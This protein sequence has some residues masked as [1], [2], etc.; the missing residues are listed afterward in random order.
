M[1]NVAAVN[2]SRDD[3]EKLKMGER[4]EAPHFEVSDLARVLEDRNIWDQ[5]P[6]LNEQLE[7][8]RIDGKSL[9]IFLSAPK[10]MMGDERHNHNRFS[11]A[12]FDGMRWEDCGLLMPDG[13]S[14]G[15]REWA[16]TAHL[17]KD[18]KLSLYYTAAGFVGEQEVSFTQ[19]L[20]SASA[21]LDTSA[22][23][24]KFLN[25]K[26]H[27]ELF[28]ADGSIYDHTNSL[29]RANGA[30]KAFRDPFYFKDP[31]SGLEYILFSGTKPNSMSEFDG[32]IGI[33][34]RT[35]GETDWTLLPPIINAEGISYELE[36]AH[37]IC[38]NDKYYLFWS[39]HGWTT[40]DDVD[41]P[42]GLYGMVSDSVLG[43][44]EP[45]NGSG[46]VISNP[47]SN[48]Y[49]A[50]SWNV[51]NDLSVSSFVDLPNGVL[52][53]SAS[54]A[55][56]PFGKFAG[57]AAPMLSIKLTEKSTRLTFSNEAEK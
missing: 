56:K 27:G 46:L 21:H 13:F 37:V 7:V 55:T 32:C 26:D 41:L 10:E 23:T 42:T 20:F 11:L 8:V 14:S 2:W 17:D 57:V 49:Q 6:V 18:N 38:A 36:R 24:P 50:Y 51:C 16:G 22:G 52:S 54:G 29:G 1:Q 25:W 31:K 9:W 45:L 30:I 33:A 4:F 5:C 28:Q 40:S 44:Y 19:R 35:L 39:M 34:S 48:P 43:P 15:S 47:R 3:V 12:T 53:T